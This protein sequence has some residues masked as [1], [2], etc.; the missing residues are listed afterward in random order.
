MQIRIRE[1]TDLDRDAQVVGKLAEQIWT[2]YYTPIIGAAQVE[3][4]LE[5]FQS[6]AAVTR[7]ITSEG[8][9]YWLAEECD[10]GPES[11]AG[12]RP[13]GY[14]GAFADKDRVL[15]LSKLYVLDTCRGQG[16][17]RRF[18]EVLERW[19]AEKGLDR[20]QLTVAKP[21]TASIAA[22]EKLGFATVGE[23][24]TDIGSGFFMD[25]YVM[26][27]RIPAGPATPSTDGGRAGSPQ[28]ATLVLLRH[29]VTDWNAE[30]R[31]QGSNADPELNTEGLTQSVEA[32]Q[33]VAAVWHPAR[34][35]SSPM[36]R[37]K[38]TAG[39]V[40][41]LVGGDIFI[42]E[43]LM[44]IDV[45]V[46]S[47]LTAAQVAALD[48]QYAAARRAGVDCRQGGTGET[49]ME[50]GARVGAALRDWARDG[51][52]TLVVSH[53]WALQM[54][55]SNLMGWDYAGSRGLRVMSNAAVSVVTRID[56]RW[57]IDIWN[58]RV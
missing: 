3:Y 35:V 36:R 54:G 50:L 52:T 37:A 14:C 11:G 25:D 43:R 34:I 55:V 13:I 33:G 24:N 51:E 18:L 26:E 30:H 32:A 31:F 23:I 21:N 10:E 2:E 45:G 15:F 47:G 4:M 40:Y 6:A 39:A 17:A 44:E 46:W 38:Q 57:R 48:P 9:Q 28:A 20:I 29:G 8:Y 49:A 53:G 7:Q 12:T 58:A 19:G 5:H 42:D 16:V 1:V 22:Y 56:G 41:S 27:R